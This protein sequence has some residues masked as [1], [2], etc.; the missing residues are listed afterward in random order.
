MS[1]IDQADPTVRDLQVDR[2]HVRVY[3]D[4]ATTGQSAARDVATEMRRLLASQ[5]T[6]RMIFA[7]APSQDSL[8]EALAG[9][10]GIDWSRVEALHMDEYVGL[11]VEA[12]GSFAAYLNT[13]LFDVVRP[14]RVALMDGA[15]D[16]EAE[17][18]RYSAE[19]T[20]GPIDLVCL[21]IGENGHIA[22]NDPDVADFADP[23]LV[24]IVAL[25]ER[26][27]RQQVNDG[28]F[29][30][31]ADVPERAITLTVP[32]LTSGGRLFCVVPGATK[33]DAVRQML[34]GAIEES[35]PASILRRHAS[36][37]LYLDAESAG[38]LAP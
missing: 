1:S 23:K 19:L 38:K 5:D 20:R 25:D 28:C 9:E 30:R 32:A 6:V 26:S 33:A 22:F 24:K 14:G 36:C 35:C 11:G 12:P 27:R 3:R 16:P 13:R 10:A 17:A 2:L 34:T 31:L 8:L 18:R 15:A 29:A 37:G 4:R 21:G 7:S